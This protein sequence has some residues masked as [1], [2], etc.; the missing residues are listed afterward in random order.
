M[1]L[2]HGKDLAREL[3]ELLAQEFVLPAADLALGE[4]LLERGKLRA[5]PLIL[6]GQ[7]GV[8]LRRAARWRCVAAQSATQLVDVPAL[9]GDGLAG[10]FERLALRG[11]SAAQLGIGRFETGDRFPRRLEPTLELGQTAADGLLQHAVRV[12]FFLQAALDRLK[13]SLDLGD[14]DAALV[15]L[16]QFPGGLVLGLFQG[17]LDA[18]ELDGEFRPELIL[19]GLDIGEG[20][21][22]GRLDPPGGEA[23]GA[24]P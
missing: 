3:A 12:L 8:G 2:G 7:S 10:K 15:G 18:A 1:R 9:A 20:H 5:Q 21:R 16:H 24:V 17:D 13:L 14:F 6:S 11:D 4:L 19:L 23:H 22:H